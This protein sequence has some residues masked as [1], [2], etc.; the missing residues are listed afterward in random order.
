MPH[1]VMKTQIDNSKEVCEYG[2]PTLR[3]FYFVLVHRV[4]SVLL[5]ILLPQPR[6]YDHHLS[7]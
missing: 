3:D 4:G 5:L 6:G 2:A 1:R 7:H